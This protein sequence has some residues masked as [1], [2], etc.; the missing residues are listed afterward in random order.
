MKTSTTLAAKFQYETSASQSVLA[1]LENQWAY[2]QSMITT[3]KE[4][5]NEILTLQY[6]INPI[7]IFGGILDMSIRY[8]N[9]PYHLEDYWP[10]G[11]ISFRIGQ[12]HSIIASYGSE[13]GG[14]NC[15][16]GICRVVPP[17]KGLRFTMTSQI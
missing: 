15:T 6:S 16:G 14:L 4:R 1:I 8:K 17:F 2:D 12:S 11:F 10:Q 5:L 7:I 13:R 3:D 9:T